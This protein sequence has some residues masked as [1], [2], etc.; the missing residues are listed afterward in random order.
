MGYY[1]GIGVGI[2]IHYLDYRKVWNVH[3]FPKFATQ[4]GWNVEVYNSSNLLNLIQYVNPDY[5]KVH[6]SDLET[7]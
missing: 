3:V 7:N 1:K 2:H 6:Y 4:G 5:I